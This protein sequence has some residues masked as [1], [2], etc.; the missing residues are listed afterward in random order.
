VPVSESR[1]VTLSLAWRFR[2]PPG[3]RSALGNRDV[4][5][6]AVPPRSEALSAALEYALEREAAIVPH[7]SEFELPYMDPALSAK[8]F[9][10]VKGIR[11]QS[12]IRPL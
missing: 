10:G 9:A 5:Q 2:A 7:G 3:L 12:Y 4:A 1:N 6:R 8:P 11:L